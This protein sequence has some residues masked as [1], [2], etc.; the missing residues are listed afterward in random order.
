MDHKP[1]GSYSGGGTDGQFSEGVSPALPGNKLLLVVLINRYRGKSIHQPNDCI[2][3]DTGGHGEHAPGVATALSHHLTGPTVI[4][5]WFLKP[6]HPLHGRNRQGKRKYRGLHGSD[7][8]I[9]GS[10]PKLCSPSDA[11]RLFWSLPL[12]LSHPKACGSL[13]VSEEQHGNSAKYV[14]TDDGVQNWTYMWD[15]LRDTPG[16]LWGT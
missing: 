10:G 9:P 14:H 3:P 12:G 4:H 2:P 7:L 11:Q 1:H 16:R 8:Y 6:T 15:R 5:G 13:H